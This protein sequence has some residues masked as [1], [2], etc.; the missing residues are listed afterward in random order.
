[1]GNNYSSE[2]IPLNMKRMIFV[3][4]YLWVPIAVVEHMLTVKSELISS[5]I[6]GIFG[7]FLSVI[8]P[9]SYRT[10]CVIGSISGLLPVLFSFNRIIRGFLLGLILSYYKLLSLMYCSGL[11][12]RTKKQRASILVN[13]VSAWVSCSTFILMRFCPTI[14]KIITYPLFTIIFSILGSIIS[15]FFIIDTP[16]EILS[17]LRTEKNKSSSY[18]HLYDTLAKI[19]GPEE[20]SIED[21]QKEYK[22]ILVIKNDKKTNSNI[23]IKIQAILLAVNVSFIYIAFQR[24]L[25]VNGTY[26]LYRCFLG[27]MQMFSWSFKYLVGPS[28]AYATMLPIAAL[29]FVCVSTDN[30][31]DVLLVFLMGFGIEFLP[32]QASGYTLNQL[33]RASVL[34]LQSFFALILFLIITKYIIY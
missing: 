24:A 17:R 15:F 20:N 22:D 18:E 9:F 29:Y 33:D 4:C 13:L 25:S 7:P 27:M 1:M 3:S 19:N 14:T 28:S 10:R 2:H 11:C 8:L 6:G 30:N 16:E 21:L 26:T 23:K 34:S 31:Q 12:V 32:A 5:I